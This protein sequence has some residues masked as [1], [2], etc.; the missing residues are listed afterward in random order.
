MIKQNGYLENLLVLF[1]FF[2]PKLSVQLSAYSNA[3]TEWTGLNKVLKNKTKNKQTNK[4]TC[5][6]GSHFECVGEGKMVLVYVGRS[7]GV[8]MRFVWRSLGVVIGVLR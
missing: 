8:L 2:P 6:Q 7:V 5:F 3:W 1:L 4:N